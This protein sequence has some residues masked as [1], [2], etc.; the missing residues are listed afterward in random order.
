M[1]L[2]EA[3]LGRLSRPSGRCRRLRAVLG[4]AGSN[5]FGLLHQ[6]A[7]ADSMRPSQRPHRH[8]NHA[9]LNDQRHDAERLEPVS[10]VIPVAG[11]GRRPGDDV[12]DE[13]QQGGP[14]AGDPAQQWC[15][16]QQEV[17]TGSCSGGAGDEPA[18]EEGGIGAQGPRKR[19]LRRRPRARFRLARAGIGI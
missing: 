19:R 17:G 16:R 2:P 14:A 3:R 5:G 10:G 4:Q 13:G 12:S 15:P 9:G 1:A 7:H 8:A 6:V 11:N 18:D